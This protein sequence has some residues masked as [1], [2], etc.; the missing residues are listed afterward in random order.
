ML[1]WG[2]SDFLANYGADE[3]G[4]TR[5]LFWS[6]LVGLFITALI[7]ALF[8]NS[9]HFP[10]LLLLLTIFSG[11]IFAIAY[12]AFY[13]AF[14]IGN[15]SVVSAVINVQTIVI[16][17]VA[18][19]IFGQRTTVLHA[20]ALPLI[21]IGASLVSVNFDDLKKGTISLLSGVKESF[22]AA[23][24]FGFY[25]SINEYLVEKLDW[26]LVNLLARFT[27]ILTVMLIA[28]LT[29]KELSIGKTSRKMLSALFFVGFL[30]IMGTLGV[31]FG[32]RIGDGIIVYPIASTLTL[33]TVSLA[34]VFLKE[35]LSKLQTIGILMTV[36]G[37]VMMGL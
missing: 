25:W 30:E 16:I 10:I 7:A 31:S 21:I 17:S 23:V 27:V 22:F 26:L 24:L 1:G 20:L 13:F 36:G 34:V 14:E 11:V 19:L 29:S 37:I 18:Y 9:F 3:L 32:L 12:L 35:K 2:T 28:K 33:V 8:I 5:T 15:V 6:Q 4:H